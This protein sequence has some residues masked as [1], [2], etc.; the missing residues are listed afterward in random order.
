MERAEMRQLTLA[1]LASRAVVWTE[2]GRIDGSLAAIG[3]QITHIEQL[4]ATRGAP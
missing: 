4:M 3:I 2:L 1:T